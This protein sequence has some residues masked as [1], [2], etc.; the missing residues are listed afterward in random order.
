MIKALTSISDLNKLIRSTLMTQAELEGNFVR[1]AS[2]NFGA[3]LDKSIDENIFS[4]IEKT[5]AMLLFDI[6]YRDSDADVSQTLEDNTLQYYKAFTV[7]VII[8][9]DSS[10]DIAYKTISRLRSQRVRT[11]LQDQAIYLEQVSEPTQLHEFVASTVWTRTDFD[12]DIDCRLLA[13]Q[14]DDDYDVSSLSD[15]TIVKTN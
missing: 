1:N 8:Y 11:Q 5:D 9:G 7:H 10:I 12:I 14:V 2:T 6:K 3:Y 13:T 4:S 15:L